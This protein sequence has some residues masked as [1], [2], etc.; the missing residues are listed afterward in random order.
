MAAKLR[1]RRIFLHCIHHKGYS[2]AIKKRRESYSRQMTCPSTV[3]VIAKLR[4]KKLVLDFNTTHD[5]PLDQESWRHVAENRRLNAVELNSVM[6]M[7]QDGVSSG[8][9]LQRM[10]EM[11]GQRGPTEGHSEYP[12]STRERHTR[13]SFRGRMLDEYLS[14]FE[15]ELS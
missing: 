5:H 12:R 9:L 13:R 14:N 2:M 6:S 11:T 3:R 4:E 1:H 7:L 15:K 8:V 10:R